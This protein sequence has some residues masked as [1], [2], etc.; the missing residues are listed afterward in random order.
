MSSVISELSRRITESC[1]AVG[2]VEELFKGVTNSML[3]V[4]YSTEPGAGGDGS[5]NKQ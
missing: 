2:E 4:E 3:S 1:K 5:I